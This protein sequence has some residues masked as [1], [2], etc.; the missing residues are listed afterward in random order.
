MRKLITL[1]TVCLGLTAVGQTSHTVNVGGSGASFAPSSLVINAGDTVYWDCTGGTHNVD[2]TLATY[3]NNPVGFG[4]GAAASSPWSYWFV[5]NT[6]GTYSYE[7]T[8]HAGGGMTGTITVNSNPLTGLVS[9]SFEGSDSWTYSISPATYNTSGDVWATVSSLSS[10][11]PSAGSSFWGIQ[12]LNNP[13]GGGAFVHT[14]DFD[15]VDISGI[16]NVYLEFDYSTIGFDG[17]DSIGYVIETNNGT[18]WGP[19]SQLDK[20]TGGSWSTVSHKLPAGTQYVRL[21][22]LAAQDGGGDYAGID[23]V[24]LVQG[25]AY[26]LEDISALTPLDANNVPTRD[27][28][29]VYIQGTVF[30]IDYD[31]NAGYSFYIHDGTDG[32]NV[33][34]SSDYGTYTNP[35]MGDQVEVLGRVDFYNGLTE[36]LVDSI[37]LVSG[38]NAIQAPTVVT[39]LDETTESELIRMNGMTLVSPSQWGSGSFNVDITDGT[40]TFTMRIDSDCDLSGTPAPVG[41]FDVIGVG[42]QY[43]NSSPYTSGYQVFPRIIEDIAYVTATLD[44]LSAVDANGVAVHDGDSALISGVVFTVDYDGN[45]GYSFYIK[46]ATSGINIYRSSD[47]SGY[48]VALGDSIRVWGVVDQYNG[49]T[50]FV[51]DSIQLMK[52]GVDFGAPMTVT[53][54]GET[55]ESEFIRINNLTLVTPSQWVTSGS[56]F[57]VDVTDGTNT[58]TMRIDSD[59]NIAGTAAPVGSFDV[60]GVGSQFDNSSPYTSGYQIL[61]RF[62]QDIIASGAVRAIE[63]IASVDV[64][65]ATGFPTRDGDTVAIR[66]VVYSIDFDGNAGYS[67]YMQDAT[68]GINVYRSSDLPNYT[69]PM[70]GDSLEIV[71]TVDFFNGLIEVAPDT[72]IV[73]GTGAAVAAPTVHTNLGEYNEGDFVRVNG[74]T[75]VTPSQWASSGSFNVDVTDGTNTFQLR[76]DSDA[77][78]GSFPAPTGMFDAIGAVGQ[79]D[80]SSPY[81]SG[82]QLFPRDT[83]DIIPA[84]ATTPTVNFVS[85]SV[86]ALESA[87]TIDVKLYI[88]P[89]AS[90][91]ET[92]DLVFTIGPGVTL[93]GDGMI[94]PT[95][96]L[97]TGALTMTV[98]AN[99]DTISFAVSI[100]D[101]ALTENDEWFDVVISG[102]SSG[103]TVGAI[104]SMRFTVIDND[105][106]IPTYTID[107]I[108]GRD[109][110]CAID[111]SLLYVKLN[112]VV[113][114]VD[115]QGA[116]SSNSAFTIWDGEGFGVFAGGLNFTVT[117]GDSI[118]VIG[119]LDEYNGLAQIYA[120]SI[121][122]IKSGST[123]P[124]PMVITS[125]DE[126]TESELVRFNN[127]TLVDPTQWGSGSS[128][129]NVDI[130]NG[131]DTITMRVD[132]DVAD[133]Y[134]MPAPIGTFDVIGIGGQFD[135]SAPRCE[136]YQLLPRY[137]ADIILPEPPT[138]DLHISEVM[139][140]SNDANGLN[141]DW[142]EITNYSTTETYNL[143]NFSFDDNS[144]IDGLNVFPSVTIAP[145]EAI[146]V[147]EGN[148]ADEASFIANWNIVNGAPQ[149]IS[150]DELTNGSFPGLSSSSDAVVLYDSS[151]NVIE[152]CKVEYTS[153]IAGFA[154]EF[155]TACAFS[156]FAVDGVNGAHTANGGDIG[157]PG[158]VAPGIGLSEANLANVRVFPN[159]TAGLVNIEL[160]FEGAKDI[161]VMDIRGAVLSVE[162]TRES[163]LQ[164]DLTQFDAGVYMLQISTGDAHRV[165]RVILQ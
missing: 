120:D 139:A 47:V 5:F 155:D 101:D 12:D 130:T 127:A 38:G 100:V 94:T 72:I 77:N 63:P 53:S 95:P 98:P 152:I 116:T 164:L 154:L 145:G 42:S 104:D 68:G 84:V 124:T 107:Q 134:A 133:V 65:D 19:L 51:P 126:T 60:I 92:V 16:S 102:A 37:Y 7:C 49:L 75:L 34:R 15:V 150:V 31:G 118:R 27:G 24:Q 148:A 137:M 30:T 6:A 10:I 17:P 41:T 143:A 35:M 83:N 57:N 76:V 109:A 45:A 20:N 28:D 40:N 160:P 78:F 61:P 86:S 66:G 67:F 108:D 123:L 117:E 25:P 140:N 163:R 157:S 55:E 58:Y 48:Q 54:L 44:T 131:T 74:L 162:S 93:P 29:T 21:R 91:S 132:A 22:I 153:T 151:S 8:P 82:Y 39:T 13:N 165:V 110:N 43:D 146:V 142:F 36:I 114:G 59:V 156:A 14:M 69:S 9:Q 4:N 159:P 99:G 64:S 111:S 3:P 125:L 141:Q 80:N 161:R 105:V 158:N 147:W 85:N 50:E 96:N 1:F 18:T 87:G 97:T 122:V 88:A 136:G 73:L 121:V 135:N 2:G 112:A 81:L 46:D 129:F 113:M 71:G 149:I 26:P 138:Y 23:N 103:L 128:G 115:L 119:E 90:T 79:Y 70:K 144:E 89:T 56:S 32:I 106:V 11:S 52:T 62:T 33:Y